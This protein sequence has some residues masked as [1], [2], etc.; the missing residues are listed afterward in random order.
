MRACVRG[1][2]Q[3]DSDSRVN[4]Q[5]IYIERESYYTTKIRHG[6]NEKRR[7]AVARVPCVRYR[8]RYRDRDRYR[9]VYRCP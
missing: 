9:Y 5:D 8:Y 3:E 1:P 7:R 4:N 6:E 2:S